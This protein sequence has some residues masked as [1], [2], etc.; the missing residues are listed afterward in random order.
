MQRTAQKATRLMPGRSSDSR[1][2]RTAH[3]PALVAAGLKRRAVS[4]Q[5]LFGEGYLPHPCRT[6][7]GYSGGTVPDF[8]GI[9]FLRVYKTPLRGPGHVLSRKSAAMDRTNYRVLKQKNPHACNRMQAW[10]FRIQSS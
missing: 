6:V 3:L 5:W 10:G 7:P 4:G 8:H 9:P 2:F 1:A